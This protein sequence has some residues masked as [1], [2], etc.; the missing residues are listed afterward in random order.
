MSPGIVTAGKK[1]QG[2]QKFQ[3][4]S[5]S[6]VAWPGTCWPIRCFRKIPDVTIAEDLGS[7]RRP[8]S[9]RTTLPVAD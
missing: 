7:G 2:K 1:P 5:K 6:G 4:S 3:R 8:R 9:E